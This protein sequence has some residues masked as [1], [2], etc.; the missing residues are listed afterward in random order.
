MVW[1]IWIKKGD[2]KM[3]KT[4]KVMALTEKFIN[5]EYGT[6]LEHFKIAEIIGE[7]FGSPQYRQI[8]NATK[9]NL[10]NSGK[11]IA[12]V[13]NVGYRVVYPDE[14][15]YQSTKYVV[16]G[17]RRIDKGVRILAHAPIKDMTQIGVQKF[18][19]VNDKMRILQSSVCRAKV[20]IKMLSEKRKNPIKIAFD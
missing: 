8:V 16:S 4:E 14:Y 5:S 9:K 7:P 3:S 10:V 15:V 1:V 17:A 20:E 6:T 2:G 12:N 11:M 13:F 18:N 19:A